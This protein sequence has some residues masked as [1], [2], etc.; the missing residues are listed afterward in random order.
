MNVKDM[1]SDHNE[2]VLYEYTARNKKTGAVLWT[3]NGRFFFTGYH[4]T[5]FFGLIERHFLWHHFKKMC[6]RKAL[7][8]EK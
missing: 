5:L 8:C 2:W 3:G 7:G 6:V 1:F 4:G